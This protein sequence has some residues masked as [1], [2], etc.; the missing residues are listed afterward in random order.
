MTIE[1]VTTKSSKYIFFYQ[2]LVI[3]LLILVFFKLGLDVLAVVILLLYT[4]AFLLLNIIYYCLNVNTGTNLHKHNNF[5]TKSVLFSV[6]IAC[7]ISSE[8]SNTYNYFNIHHWNFINYNNIYLLNEGSQFLITGQHAIFVIYNL[9]ESALINVYI[10]FGLIFSLTI[11]QNLKDVAKSDLGG[12]NKVFSVYN[13]LNVSK[14]KRTLRR[15]SSTN[16]KS[17]K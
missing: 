7:V 11:C 12:I 4:S 3:Y 2:V 8:Y 16:F 6:Y 17:N 9:V 10:L 14:L 1:L 5:Y 15:K 13:T